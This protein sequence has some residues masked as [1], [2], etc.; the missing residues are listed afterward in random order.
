MTARRSLNDA[1]DYGR[2]IQS[3]HDLQEL[4]S[5][6]VSS[7]DI[8][9]VLDVSELRADAQPKKITIGK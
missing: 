8:L 6:E 5:A 9:A 1:L 2:K 3:I 4:S 7:S